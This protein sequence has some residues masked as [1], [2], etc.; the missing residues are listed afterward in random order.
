M[1]GIERNTGMRSAL[2]KVGLTLLSVINT[3]MYDLE[4]LKECR[5]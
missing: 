1:S 2:L 5:D 4:E 3:T